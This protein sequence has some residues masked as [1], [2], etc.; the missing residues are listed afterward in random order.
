MRPSSP[1]DPNAPYRA[2]IAS[3]VDC[4][5]L[6]DEPA[7]QPENHNATHHNSPFAEL[8]SRRAFSSNPPRAVADAGPSSASAVN[9]GNIRQY[10]LQMGHS[11][12]DRLKNEVIN[13]RLNSAN[14]D[15][16]TL[17]S[18]IQSVYNINRPLPENMTISRQERAEVIYRLAGIITNRSGFLEAMKNAAQNSH[19]DPDEL[20]KNVLR[21]IRNID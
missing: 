10:F 17:L 9:I 14:L 5:F 7:E 12:T 3:L 21:H 16:E 19:N 1:S 20:I 18:A 4:S 15:A 13:N 2:A 6:P 11:N 8:S